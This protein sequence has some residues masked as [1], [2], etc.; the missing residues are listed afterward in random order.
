MADLKLIHGGARELPEWLTYPRSCDARSPF[1]KAAS[2]R[3]RINPER[4]LLNAAANRRQPA[5]EL[6]SLI[7]GTAPP[8]PNVNHSCNAPA[9]QGLTRL[10]DARACFHGLR[11]PVA[12]SDHG[13]EMLTYILEPSYY[14]RFDT[15]HAAATVTIARR[16]PVPTGLLFL[17]HVRMDQPIGT[18]D[19]PMIGSVTHWGFA[20]RSNADPALP[21]DF[22]SRFNGRHW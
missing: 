17:A 14:Y 16:V 20:Q 7:L 3:V 19:P 21:V 22:D 15:N 1:D 6:W 12:E 5:F 8:V 4:A 18:G 13:D 10:S 2:A 11:R 9:D